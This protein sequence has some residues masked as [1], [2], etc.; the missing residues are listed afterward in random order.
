MAAMTKTLKLCVLLG[1]LFFLLFNFPLAQIFNFN[2]LWLGVPV[3]TWYFFTV[4]LLAIV[5]LIFF[6]RRL[7]RTE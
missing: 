5:G 1:I 2:I 4:W 7:N 3:L 6:G